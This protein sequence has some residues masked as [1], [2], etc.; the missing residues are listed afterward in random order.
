MRHYDQNELTLLYYGE[1]T[2]EGHLAVCLEC[3]AQM[4]QLSATLDRVR[5]WPVPLRPADYAARVWQGL[6]PEIRLP[7]PRRQFPWLAAG[8]AIAALLVLAFQLGRHTAPEKITAQTADPLIGERI[9]EAAIRDHLERSRMVLAELANGTGT[10]AAEFSLE[11]GRAEVLLR[12]NRLYRQTAALSGM[13]QVEDT[14]EDLERLLVEL[15]NAPEGSG[16]EVV[17]QTRK[18]ME[19]Q[20]LLFRVRILESQFRYKLE[21]KGDNL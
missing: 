2:D 9:R 11:R 8:A 16:P 14:L 21:P 3:Q 12:E 17:L 19:Q 18:R 1:A 4:M 10:G 6:A 13:A 15:S 5:E 20:Q 7:Y